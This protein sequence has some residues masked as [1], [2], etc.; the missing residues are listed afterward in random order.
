MRTPTFY[1]F[2]RTTSALRWAAIGAVITGLYSLL[3]V[4]KEH[5]VFH[6]LAD[7]SSSVYAG[8]E[9]LLGLLLVLRSNAAY[10][11]WWEGRTLWGKLVNVS[12]NLVVKAET[13]VEL[14]A[15]DV[16]VLRKHVIAFAGEL[17]DHL[18]EKHH[19][20]TGSATGQHSPSLRVREIYL[21]IN[22]WRSRGIVSDDL[23]RVLDSE[24]R[25]FL[26]VCGGCERILKTPL[27]RSYRSFLIKGIALVLLSL[28][29]SLASE[30]GIW[31]VPVTMINA[32]FF[33]GVQVLART[34]ED[35]FGTEA[36]DLDLDRIVDSIA[37]S[38]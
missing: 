15:E 16:A 25:E 36:D 6:G 29:W 28:P 32:Y 17:R 26:E 35:P 24:A 3:P 19:G 38:V 2:V 4:W 5:S 21:L 11:R 18:R 1:H 37:R 31:A 22:Q 8:V 9:V 13:L 30:I 12:R 23:L 34:V 20:Q 27:S 7:H 10:Q 14:S 33:I